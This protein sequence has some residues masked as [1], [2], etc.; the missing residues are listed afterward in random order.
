MLDVG[1]YWHYGGKLCLLC[2][3]WNVYWSWTKE[4]VPLDCQAIRNKDTN[5]TIWHHC[6]RQF[7]LICHRV[8][9][10]SVSNRSGKP[11]SG[12]VLGQRFGSVP[13][14]T[15]QKPDP[16]CLGGFVSRPGHRNLGFWHGW[17]RTAVPNIQFP[18]VSLQFSLWVLIE[19]SYGQYVHRSILDAHSPPAIRIGIPPIF[20]ESLWNNAKCHP[21]FA[22]FLSWLSEYWSD[23]QSDSG[24][25][26]SA[27]TCPIYILIM[28]WHDW[29]SHT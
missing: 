4:N 8:F 16:H 2:Q 14:Q 29:N 17:N 13:Y 5:H 27:K 20:I 3:G 7:H 18:L 24:R 23:H 10:T 6:Q 9:E 15:R 11:S 22:G 1:R 12:P 21:I 25:W 28:S 26:N 19:S